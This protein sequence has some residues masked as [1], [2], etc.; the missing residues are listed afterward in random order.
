MTL[1]ILEFNQGADASLSLSTSAGPLIIGGANSKILQTNSGPINSDRA[2]AEPD[3]GVTTLEGTGY[4]NV[5]FSSMLGLS[6][7]QTLRLSTPAVSPSGQV[8]TIAGTGQMAG[9]VELTSGNLVIGPQAL[10]ER[11]AWH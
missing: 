7:G 8:I 3:G 2:H 5:T 6:V 10:G 4:G 1:N 9:T 11:H